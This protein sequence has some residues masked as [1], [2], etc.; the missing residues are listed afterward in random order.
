[1]RRL[2]FLQRAQQ[3]VLTSQGSAFPL[4]AAIEKCC[5]QAAVPYSASISARLTDTYSKQTGHAPACRSAALQL[6]LPQSK[7]RLAQCQMQPSSQMTSSR[8]KRSAPMSTLLQHCSSLPMS[9]CFASHHVGLSRRP[10][11][12]VLLQVHHANIRTARIGLHS[13]RGCPPV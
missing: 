2:A 11:V 8:R 7:M 9:Y 4:P 6:Q 10:H 1:M 12:A 5:H 13:W 3:A